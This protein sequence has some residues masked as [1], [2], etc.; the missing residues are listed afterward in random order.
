MTP[1][2]AARLDIGDLSV[3]CSPQVGGLDVEPGLGVRVWVFGVEGGFPIFRSF[4]VQ[5]SCDNFLMR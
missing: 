2:H 4:W 5:L 3:L 1:K